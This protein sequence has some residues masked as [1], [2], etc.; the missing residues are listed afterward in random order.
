MSKIGDGTVLAAGKSYI[1]I[2]KAKSS[3]IRS[4]SRVKSGN[5][6][7]NFR[8]CLMIKIDRD[9]IPLYQ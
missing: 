2:Q 9:R 7:K 1:T 3:V 8:Y 5:I 6:G 4:S